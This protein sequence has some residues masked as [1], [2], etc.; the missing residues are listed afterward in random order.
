MWS[1]P[2]VSVV[3]KVQA[4]ER[5]IGGKVGVLLVVH[6]TLSLQGGRSFRED[7]SVGSELVW[8]T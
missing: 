2:A 7:G 8:T 6:Q 4:G 3:I 1:S 5:L